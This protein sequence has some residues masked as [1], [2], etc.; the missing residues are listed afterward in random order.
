MG[1]KM[2]DETVSDILTVPSLS[3]APLANTNVLGSKTAIK[4]INQDD[5]GILAVKNR[6]ETGF[7][8]KKVASILSE[9]IAKACFGNQHDKGAK[10]INTVDLKRKRRQSQNVF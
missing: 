10:I 8:P 5:L 7:N 4:A 1:I 9:N 3:Y 2:Q 6:N